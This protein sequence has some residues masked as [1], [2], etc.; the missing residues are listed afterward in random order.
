MDMLLRQAKVFRAP[1]YQ[2][3]PEPVTVTLQQYPDEMQERYGTIPNIRFVTTYKYIEKFDPGY[4]NPK[5]IQSFNQRHSSRLTTREQIVTDARRWESHNEAFLLMGGH[6]RDMGIDFYISPETMVEVLEAAPNTFVGVVFAELEETDE[7][8]TAAVQ[9]QLLPLAEKFYKHGRKKILL[10]NKNIFWN[11]NVH[12]DLFK[13]TIMS[14]PRYRE[15]FVPSMEETNSRTQGLSLAG[16]TG[17][18][19]TE[20]FDHISG[21]A[22][23]DNANWNRSWEW[24]QTMHLSHFIRAL[25]LSRVYGA[26][27]FHINIYT[28]N[29]VEMLPLFH[30]LGSGALPRP[31]RDELLSLSN[32]A[33]GMTRPDEEFIRHGTNGHG[34]DRYAPDTAPF[35]LD[36]L[37]GFWGAAPV[38]WYDLTNIAYNSQRRQMNFIPRLPYGMVTMIAAETNPSDFAYY[39]QVLRTDGRY[40]YDDQDQPHAADAWE[41]MVRETL[42]AAAERLPVR[43]LGDVSW[44]AVRIDPTHVRVILIDPG[45]L[46]PADREA[47]IVMQHLQTVQCTDILSGETLPV[48]DNRT[49]VRVPMGILRIIDVEH[50]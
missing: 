30:L 20:R 12:L 48:I 25:S 29:K 28:D 13:E 31:E 10:R 26:D 17:L 49:A 5:F 21:R 45:Y 39:R 4:T 47:T 3:E 43:V 7:A 50:R 33:I 41:P 19:L 23:T 16:R 22:V 8:L 42:E 44:S 6:G 24:G 40:W 9:S 35:V 2:P 36:R 32:V 15:V 34:L 14:D 27:L 46:D 1:A 37:D 11:G 18:W 38:P